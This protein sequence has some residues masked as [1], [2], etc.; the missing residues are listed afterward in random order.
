ME[1]I[2]RYKAFDGQ[3]FDNQSE[4][5]KYEA[6]LLNRKEIECK[7]LNCLQIHKSTII[8]FLDLAKGY[9][10]TFSIAEDCKGCVFQNDNLTCM[11]GDMP[12]DFCLDDI[13]ALISRK[14]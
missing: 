13:E 8:N 6:D 2:K 5:M 9:C 12:E 14:E 10:N 3:M 1:E 4:C 11:L 7:M